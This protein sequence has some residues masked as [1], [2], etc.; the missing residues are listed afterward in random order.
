MCSATSVLLSRAFLKV[1]KMDVC[2]YRCLCGQCG[3]T[4]QT[5][6]TPAQSGHGAKTASF[7]LVRL[8]ASLGPGFSPP[9]ELVETGP[10]CT[11]SG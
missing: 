3:Q 8:T 1:F 2:M 4:K 7:P 11:E 5:E 10:T 6:A 9:S